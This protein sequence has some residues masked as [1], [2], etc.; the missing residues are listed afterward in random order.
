M[1]T[2]SKFSFDALP[3]HLSQSVWTGAVMGKRHGPTMSSGHMLLD[4]NL[5]GEGWPAQSLTEILQPQV[6][7]G[8]WRLLMPAVRQLVRQGGSVILISPPYPPYLPALHQEGLSADRLIWVDTASQ[9]QRLWATEQALQASCLTAILVWLPH[10]K[11]EHMRR[12]QNC[13]TQHP[14]L[15]FAMRPLAARHESSAAPLRLALSLDK[16]PHPLQVQILKRKGPV[17]DQT[18]NLPCWQPA[19]A[20]LITPNGSMQHATLDRVD[21]RAVNSLAVH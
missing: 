19:L 4:A 7:Q 1:H 10:A 21:T 6:G 5:P 12:L 15:L 8:E 14:G 17:L 3:E 16:A 13:A 18:L 2:V 11:P 9:A 20:H